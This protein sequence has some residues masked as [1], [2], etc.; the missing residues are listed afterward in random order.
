VLADLWRI[1]NALA[2]R[3]LNLP[4]DTLEEKAKLFNQAA[5]EPL[6]RLQRQRPPGIC[7]FCANVCTPGSADR[8]LADMKEA[9]IRVLGEGD[10][11]AEALEAD[12]APRSCGVTDPAC[13]GRSTEA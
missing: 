12:P 4:C 1:R 2:A 3:D 10:Q 6:V 5:G 7:L 11:Q 9:L 13:R 8:L